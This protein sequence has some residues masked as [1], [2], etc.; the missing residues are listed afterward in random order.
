MPVTIPVPVTERKALVWVAIVEVNRLNVNVSPPPVT[1]QS[2]TNGVEGLKTQG[3]AKVGTVAV[4]ITVNAP[5]VPFIAVVPHV[6][7][8]LAAVRSVVVTA[9]PSCSVKPLPTAD[10]KA[11]VPEI[12]AAFTAGPS[13]NASSR[14]ALNF[15]YE[16][17]FISVGCCGGLSGASSRIGWGNIRRGQSSKCRATRLLLF[18]NS[19]ITSWLECV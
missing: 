4:G 5:E 9:D 18:G 16:R 17:V 1:D 11:I 13:A 7:T 2:P 19:L 10:A 6:F 8:P 12:G 15:E 3:A 14:D